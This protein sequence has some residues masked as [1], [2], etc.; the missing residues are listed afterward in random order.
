MCVICVY[1]PDANNVFD[2][3]WVRFTFFLQVFIVTVQKI[4]VFNTLQYEK[5]VNIV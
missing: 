2:C 3:V 4:C 1:V 5:Y